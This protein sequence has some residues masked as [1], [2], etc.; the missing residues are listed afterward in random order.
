VNC[1]GWNRVLKA[2]ITTTARTDGTSSGTPSKEMT[3]R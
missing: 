2:S 3:N 1:T